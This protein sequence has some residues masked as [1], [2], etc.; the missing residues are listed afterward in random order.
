MIFYFSGTGNSLWAARRLSRVLGQ[1]EPVAVADELRRHPSGDCV[2]ELGGGECLILVFPVHSWGPAELMLRFVSRLSIRDYAGQ[3]VYA[4]CTCGDTCGWTDRIL[5]EALRK[6]GLSLAGCWSVRMPNNYI[7][8]KGFG[9][10]ADD[11]REAKLAA[12][13]AAVDAVAE[14]IRAHEGGVHL[15]V[16]SRPW[17]K[18]RIINPL[19]RRFLAGPDSRTKYHVA[20]TCIGCGLCARVCPTGTVTMKDGRPE[21]GRGC[22]QCTACINRCPVR[23]VEY[24]GITQTQGRYHHPDL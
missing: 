1:A 23:A 4:V 7:L 3:K 17:L 18:S 22:V 20:D 12:A 15:T 24:G 6:R 5:G 11:V 13:P 9:V 14:A 19:F 16:G 8:M 21:W 2:Y 10:D